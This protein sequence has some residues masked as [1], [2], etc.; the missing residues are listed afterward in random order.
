MDV[1]HVARMNERALR[2]LIAAHAAR[3]DEPLVLAVRYRRADPDVHLLEVL[4]DFPAA[5]G[6]EPFETEFAPS[7]ELML[8]GKLHLTLVS[9]AQLDSMIERDA[10]L[11]R[12]LRADGAVEYYVSSARSLIE[13]LG[14]EATASSAEKKARMELLRES[15]VTATPEEM[16]EIRKGWAS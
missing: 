3:F 12:A 5:A 10:P 11:V 15:G 7:P 13:R 9:P 14:L 2:T 4:E 8:L 6:E 1:A 16:E